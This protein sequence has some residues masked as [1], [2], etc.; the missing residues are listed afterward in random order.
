MM[1]QRCNNPHFPAY[2]HYGGRG[3]VICE[4]WSRFENFLADMGNRPTPE[5]EL[6]RIDNDGPYSPSN[7][8]WTTCTVNQNNRRSNRILE[9]DG[10]RLTVAEWSR[11]LGV[12][13]ATLYQRLHQGWSV[14]RCLVTP[15]QGRP[16]T[17]T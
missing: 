7:C 12:K 11:E 16:S 2:P 5:H 14:E 17:T 8:R 4:R 6:D 10:K 15:V 1:R 9:W 3:I 13:A